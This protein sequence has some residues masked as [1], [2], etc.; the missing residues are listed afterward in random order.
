MAD[1]KPYRRRFSRTRI[2][3]VGIIELESHK[4]REEGSSSIYGR[5]EGGGEVGTIGEME[6]RST[7]GERN[8]IMGESRAKLG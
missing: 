2:D 1:G 8:R 3:L 6:K 7:V 4:S 5:D